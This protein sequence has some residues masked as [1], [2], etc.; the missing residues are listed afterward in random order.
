[1]GLYASPNPEVKT[2]RGLHLYHF[3]LSNCSQRVR[4]ALEEKGLPWTSHH[5]NLAAN[6]HVTPEYWTLNPNGV[7]PT[8]VH[9][10]RVYI[11]S[12]DIIR[13][14]DETFPEPPLARKDP[15]ERAA[16][17]RHLSAAEAIQPSIKALSHELL[18]KPFRKVSAEEIERID[19]ALGNAELVAFLR[20]YAEDGA[21]WRAR[22]E[23]ATRAMDEALAHLE[24]ALADAPWLSGAAFGLA[25]VSWA[26]N[27]HRL[28]QARYPLDAHPRLRGWYERI[29]ERP[30]FRRAVLEWRPG[31]EA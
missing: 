12:N 29:L 7:V 18:F 20:D 26:V 10:G 24:A 9:D 28:T 31:G 5:L 19:A 11:E 25:D 30:S 13:Y 4:I 17:E 8:L 15:A 14:L 6:E 16:L 1:M 23:A 27:L 21:A 2:F 22:V 3:A